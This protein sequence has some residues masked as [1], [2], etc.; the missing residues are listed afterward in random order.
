MAWQDN[1]RTPIHLSCFYKT[2]QS[3]SV[4][5]RQHLLCS[6]RAKRR[7]GGRQYIAK[8]MGGPS[9]RDHSIRCL[10]VNEAL[11]YVE[12]LLKAATSR[13]K[14]GALS[15]SPLHSPLYRLQSLWLLATAAQYPWG[16]WKAT[17]KQ[18]YG[19]TV[20]PTVALLRW[21]MDTETVVHSLA[22]GEQYGRRQALS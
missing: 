10:S 19:A 5:H 2:P 20:F 6:D 17:M 12:C 11:R 15:S 18:R 3:Q 22:A 14:T 9:R 8:V 21:F 16:I 13:E 1:S 4:L 7:I